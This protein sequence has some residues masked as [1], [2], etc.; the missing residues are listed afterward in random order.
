M[1]HFRWIIYLN[2]FSRRRSSQSR[3]WRSSRT[4]QTSYLVLEERL[5]TS[6]R[7]TV[8]SGSTTTLF[9]VTLFISASTYNERP[10]PIKWRQPR[11]SS[12]KLPS[13]TSHLEAAMVR[14]D[15]HVIKRPTLQRERRFPGTLQ[16]SGS[17]E[18]AASA[19]FITVGS[20]N[21]A[22]SYSFFQKG[23]RFITSKAFSELLKLSREYQMLTVTKVT[24]FRWTR[25]QRVQSNSVTS[26]RLHKRSPTLIVG[27]K[28]PC[29][30][31]AIF[32]RSCMARAQPCPASPLPS[33][34]Q[35]PYGV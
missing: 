10:P 20:R 17:R 1:F 29:C 30:L 6:M 3:D 34:T 28:E 32:P 27:P 25:S 11:R 19:R 35:R 14:A 18:T 13:P 7:F 5:P 24:D 4:R 15:K 21:Q 22:F 23:L 9:T 33:K 12:S 26:L 31:L 8:E 16:P 2:Y